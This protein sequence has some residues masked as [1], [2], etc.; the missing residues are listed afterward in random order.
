MKKVIAVLKDKQRCLTTQETASKN[1]WWITHNV[2]ATLCAD[3]FP[4]KKNYSPSCEPIVNN[5]V[6]GLRGRYYTLS[7]ITP[8]EICFTCDGKATMRIEHLFYCKEHFNDLVLTKPIIR[9]TAKINRNQLCACGSTKKY[10]HCCITKDQ[11]TPRH[12]FNSAYK[13][14]DQTKN[15]S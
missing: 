1:N 11:H 7:K 10:K 14:L 9:A 12:Y 3:K 5:V 4:P 15:S 2:E 13:P 8:V 6:S